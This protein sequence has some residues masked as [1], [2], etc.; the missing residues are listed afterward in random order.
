M[1]S[2]F[3]RGFAFYTIVA[4][5]SAGC[6][7]L[8]HVWV[9]NQVVQV[10]YE[11]AREKR[12][13]EELAQANQ[14]LRVEVDWLKNPARIEQLAR[15]DLRMEAPDPA[16]IRVVEKKSSPLSAVSSQP[17]RKLAVAQVRR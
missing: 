2:R 4:A 5:G 10:G 13:S 16:H 7:A 1:S 3:K 15:R 8:A 9:R 6:A 14:R 11:L 17:D 12:A